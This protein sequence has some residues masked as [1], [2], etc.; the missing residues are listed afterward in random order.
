MKLLD[1]LRHR[2]RLH[3]Q[4]SRRRASPNCTIS[5][6]DDPMERRIFQGD[7]KFSRARVTGRTWCCKTANETVRGLG[8]LSSQRAPIPHPFPASSPSRYKRTRIPYAEMQ[9][10][11]TADVPGITPD[12]TQPANPPQYRGE[13]ALFCA[14]LSRV[15]H[16][17]LR[18]LRLRNPRDHPR[19]LLSVPLFNLRRKVPTAESLP[20]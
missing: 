11:H 8:A 7:P 1:V 5:S 16:P 15:V 17:T 14:M 6:P 2:L 9:Y 4:R 3:G 18:E 12:F 13:Y 10:V 19:V 20:L